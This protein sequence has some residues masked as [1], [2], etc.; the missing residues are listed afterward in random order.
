VSS[1]AELVAILKP[2]I[3]S[4]S[5]AE[6]S[7]DLK[8]RLAMHSIIVALPL[9]PFASLL[10]PV[11]ARTLSPKTYVY[12]WTKIV[13]ISLSLRKSGVKKTS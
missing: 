8:I 2:D 3:S 12:V 6:I 10:R 13:Q 1:Q 5:R 9:C 4:R 11:A 7:S